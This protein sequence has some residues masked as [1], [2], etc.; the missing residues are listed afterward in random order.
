MAEVAARRFPAP[1]TVVELHE[2]FRIVDADGTHL[3]Y[4]HFCDDP[5]RRASTNRLSRDEAR[6]IAGTMAAAPDM[7]TELSDHDKSF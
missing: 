4:V 3:A 7:R 1:W 2:A 6:R 5:K